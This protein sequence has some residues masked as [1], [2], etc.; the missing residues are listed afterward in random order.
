MINQDQDVETI[1]RHIKQKLTTLQESITRGNRFITMLEAGYEQGKSRTQN[2]LTYAQKNASTF[3]S[4]YR[5]KIKQ[6]SFTHF[7]R[8]KD[9]L[10]QAWEHWKPSINKLIQ[11]SIVISTITSAFNMA[12][13]IAPIIFS[14]LSVLATAPLMSAIIPNFL[15]HKT[16]IML[17][18]SGI[19]I[20]AGYHKYYALIKRAEL[21]RQIRRNQEEIRQ[22]KAKLEKIRLYTPH[23][24]YY[25]RQRIRHISHDKNDNRRNRP[26]VA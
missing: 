1:K 8:L 5:K 18:L 16:S 12:I 17:I 4:T 26:R 21:D 14:V 9:Q 2:T 20:F 3:F 19:S 22:L 15:L 6:N 11:A 23:H 7:N 24:T 10:Q 25:L 13:K